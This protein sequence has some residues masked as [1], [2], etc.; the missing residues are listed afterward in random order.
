MVSPLEGAQP[1]GTEW[2]R[3]PRYFLEFSDFMHTSRLEYQW[4]KKS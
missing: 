3:M 1:T 4:Q 2:A